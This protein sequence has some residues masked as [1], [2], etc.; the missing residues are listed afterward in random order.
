MY[1]FFKLSHFFFFAILIS[2]TRAQFE[3]EYLGE[4][5]KKEEVNS[6]DFCDLKNCALDTNELMYAATQ[7]ESV[8][9]CVDFKEFAL[10]TYLKFRAVNDRD[11]YN[12]FQFEILK[13]NWHHKKTVLQAEINEE[14]DTRVFKV[15][16]QFYQ[17]CVDAGKFSKIK[18]TWAMKSFNRLRQSQRHNW[19]P[20]LFEVLGWIAVDIWR[21]M[22]F[23][24]L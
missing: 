3:L 7:N 14:K 2:N 11:Q 12:G 10:G 21:R 4:H 6:R 13:A 23:W 16:K 20:W 22:E 19:D 24:W 9:P 5:V 17:K 15:M 18:K 1:F 8:D